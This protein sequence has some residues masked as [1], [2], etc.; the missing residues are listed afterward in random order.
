MR[1]TTMHKLFTTALVFAVPILMGTVVVGE[2][3]QMPKN[4]ETQS[5]FEIFIRQMDAVLETQIEEMVSL[6]SPDSAEFIRKT[7]REWREIVELD[8]EIRGRQETASLA[9]LRCLGSS[10]ERRYQNQEI[11]IAELEE[12]R[13]RSKSPKAR[14][15]TIP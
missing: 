2:H 7:F 5:D 8:C 14:R 6:S 10:L 4:P 3:N 1:H 11:R 12:E 13:D 9:K 15:I